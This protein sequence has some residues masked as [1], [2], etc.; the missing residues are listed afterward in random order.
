MRTDTSRLSRVLWVTKRGVYKY[1]PFSVC[2]LL[3]IQLN[4][5]VE[6]ALS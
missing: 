4:R 1:T 3:Y 5:Y 6:L 2:M